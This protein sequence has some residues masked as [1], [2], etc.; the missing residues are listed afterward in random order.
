MRRASSDSGFFIS[1]VLNLVFRFQWVVAAVVFFIL[2]KLVDEVPLWPTF[3][4]L[5][6]WVVHSLVVTIAL[7]AVANM[8][9]VPHEPKTNKNPYSKKTEDLFKNKNE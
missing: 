2:Y 6:F 7:C 8:P 3:L 4:A 9:D 5:G 1:L